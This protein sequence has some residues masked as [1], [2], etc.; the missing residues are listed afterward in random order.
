MLKEPRTR[1]EALQPCGEPARVS[2]DGAREPA[3]V[4]LGGGKPGTQDAKFKE[5]LSLGPCASSRLAPECVSLNLCPGRLPRFIRSWLCR[6]D[7]IR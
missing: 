6:Y 3:W 7:L 1:P 5:T 4:G 2:G